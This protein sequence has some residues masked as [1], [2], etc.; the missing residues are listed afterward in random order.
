MGVQVLAVAMLVDVDVYPVPVQPPERLRTE[1][2]DHHADRELQPGLHLT[3]DRQ[4]QKHHDSAEAEQRQGVP[5][6]PESPT[7]DQCTAVALL[8][9][10]V[11]HSGQVIGF[12]RMAHA[13]DE[14]QQQDRIVTHA[15]ISVP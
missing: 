9:Q 15:A 10:H 5:Q 13:D 6:P 1:R 8:G 7:N 3:R 4:A 12:K 2:H 11:G 14:S